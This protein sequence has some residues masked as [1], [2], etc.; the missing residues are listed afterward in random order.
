MSNAL[1]P[2]PFRGATLYIVNHEGQPYTAM[3]PIAEGMGLSWQGQHE[4]LSANKERWSIK[5]I[6]TVAEDGK[7]RAQVCMSLR[8]LPG[9]LMTIYPNKVKPEIRDTI[10][11]YQNECDDVL[12]QYWN[13]GQAVNPRFRPEKTR[14]ALSG[15][16]TLEQ[17][18]AVKALIKSRVEILPHDSQAKAAITCWSAIKSKF[19]VSYK[20][21]PAEHFS[22]VLSLVARLELSKGE[23]KALPHPSYTFPATFW[24]QQPNERIGFLTWQDLVNA[25]ARP[26]PALLARLTEDGNDIEGARIEYLAMR[27]LMELQNLIITNVARD[28]LSYPNRG[29][30]VTLR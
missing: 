27:H 2:V 24:R 30:S 1:I 22:E 7:Q 5:E 6:L 3:R 28:V 11:A 29:L 14:K 13:Q 21:V 23:P 4:K 25:E 10:I 19:G 17:Q 9:W 18:D 16:L 15:G 26:L 12:W 8:K 20:A